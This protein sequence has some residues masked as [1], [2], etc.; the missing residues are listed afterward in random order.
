MRG[1]VSIKLEAAFTVFTVR[2]SV[3]FWPRGI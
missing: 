2:F 3:R 1:V